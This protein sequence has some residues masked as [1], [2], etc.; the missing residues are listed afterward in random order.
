MHVGK[1]RENERE[2]GEERSGTWEER[3]RERK[4]EE[5][6]RSNYERD[7]PKVA[8]VESGHKLRNA[9]IR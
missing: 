5:K 8:W 2:G 7:K 1:E 3:E 6:G 4:T 9:N